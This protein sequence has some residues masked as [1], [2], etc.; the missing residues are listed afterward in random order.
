[1]QCSNCG[2]PFNMLKLYNNGVIRLGMHCV[3]M[4]VLLSAFAYVFHSLVCLVLAEI[5]Y[6]VS[7]AGYVHNYLYKYRRTSLRAPRLFPALLPYLG[8]DCPL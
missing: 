5:I 2:L 3:P 6:I 1:M 4:F 8:I 7:G